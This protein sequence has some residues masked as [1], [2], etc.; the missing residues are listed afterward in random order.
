ME[1]NAMT[2]KIKYLILSLLMLSTT[3]SLFAQK[4]FTLEECLEVLPRTM[5]TALGRE[6]TH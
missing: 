6:S 5:A 4:L 3:G 2:M 1:R